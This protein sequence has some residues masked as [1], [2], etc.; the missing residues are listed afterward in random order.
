MKDRIQGIKS[1]LS[2][3]TR[4]P[5]LQQA[6][7]HIFKSAKQKYTFSESHYLQIKYK[8]LGFLYLSRLQ[9]RFFQKLPFNFLNIRNQKAGL[10]IEDDFGL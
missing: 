5:S 9:N 4:V 7:S 1:S 2:Q 3:A 6:V 8:K 10:V